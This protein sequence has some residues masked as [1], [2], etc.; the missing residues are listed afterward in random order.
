MSSNL[1]D[2]LTITYNIIKQ[3]ESY[4]EYVEHLSTL[5]DNKLKGDIQECFIRLYFESH[6]VHYNVKKYYAR[7][8]GELPDIDGIN[9]KDW[10]VDGYIEHNDGKFSFVQ[11]KFRSDMKFNLNKRGLRQHGVRSRT[12]TQKEFVT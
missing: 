8:L 1:E 10:G 9:N 2:I 3:Y 11:V 12:I 4:D 7:V 6:R 5:T